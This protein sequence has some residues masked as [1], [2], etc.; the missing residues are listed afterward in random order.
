[1]LS[2]LSLHMRGLLTHPAGVPLSNHRRSI[3]NLHHGSDSPSTSSI[4][5]RP[6]P[7]FSSLLSAPYVGIFVLAAL[8]P[9]FVSNFY[10][11][12]KWAAVSTRLRRA[13]ERAQSVRSPRRWK[14]GRRAF[15][16][17]PIFSSDK[18]QESCVEWYRSADVA[19]KTWIH[20][21]IPALWRRRGSSS[22]WHY[23]S[24]PCVPTYFDVKQLSP[25]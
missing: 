14:F 18:P 9:V 3:G 20:S 5:T 16:L 23:R 22:V 2:T 15:P 12:C 17:S 25:E 7:S 1:M 19:D 4:V 13:G 24:Q 8:M 6:S 21:I 10:W 11:I